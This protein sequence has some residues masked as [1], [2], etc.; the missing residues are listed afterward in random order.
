LE[1]FESNGA[2]VCGSSENVS[3]SFTQ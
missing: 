1:Y 3:G 2:R